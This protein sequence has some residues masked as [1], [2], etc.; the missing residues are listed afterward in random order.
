[1]TTPLIRDSQDPNTEDS[2]MLDRE[3]VTHY[4][5][6]TMRMGYLSQDRPDLMRAVREL[7]KGMQNPTERHLQMLKRAVRYLVNAPRAVQ[8]VP[9][10]R[11]LTHLDAYTDSDH[12]GCIR[13]RKSTSGA[14]IMMGD[15]TLKT[16][17][18]GQAV[19][20]L[21]SGE[22]EYYGLISAVSDALGEQAFLQDWGIHLP[23]VLHVDSTAGASIASRR[24]L[25]RMKHI[26]T[27]LL[28]CRR[29]SPKS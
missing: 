15:A 11:S 24:G 4:R 26:R 10:Q 8:R 2:K 25:G 14:C 19:I 18:K 23:I 22:A 27:C 12:A 9:P 16:S 7:A 29:R 28:G 21:S 3:T 1:M 5:S 20:A 13:T 17:C 6:N